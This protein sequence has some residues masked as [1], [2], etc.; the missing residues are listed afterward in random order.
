MRR[1]ELTLTVYRCLTRR[2]LSVACEVCGEAFKVGE[3][4]VANQKG[5][6]T[7]RYHEACWEGLYEKFYQPKRNQRSPYVKR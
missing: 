3:T 2:G 1:F 6:H 7:K 5:H 4:V